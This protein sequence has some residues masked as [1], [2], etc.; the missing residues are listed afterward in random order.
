MARRDEA[1]ITESPRAFQRYVDPTP[2]AIPSIAVV[3]RR[4]TILV[5]LCLSQFSAVPATTQVGQKDH[6]IIAGAIVRGSLDERKIALVFT[7]HEFAESGEII[8]DQLARHRAKASFFFTGDFLDDKEHASLIRRVVADGHYLGPH[9]DKHLLYCGWNA[10]RKTLL[11]RDEFRADVQANL[12]K[13][14]RVGIQP[15]D[16]RYFLL[17]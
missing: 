14:E 9:S 17:S 3:M 5:L 4:M 12:A 11:T 10:E 7:A 13:I 2:D 6:Q 8:L 15:A 1:R 16:I